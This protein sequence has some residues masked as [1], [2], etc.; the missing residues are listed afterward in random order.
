[1]T[2]Y[3]LSVSRN[4]EYAE[5][6]IAFAVKERIMQLIMYA[7][8]FAQYRCENPTCTAGHDEALVMMSRCHPDAGVVALLV[9]GE[10]H[11]HLVC[12]ICE[13]PVVTIAIAHRRPL[14]FGSNS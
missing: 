6:D 4:V 9:P 10:D 2:T 13:T 14:M 5:D 8:D 3:A 12:Q 7:E 1:M 11:L